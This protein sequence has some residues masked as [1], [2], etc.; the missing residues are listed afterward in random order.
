MAINKEEF[1]DLGCAVPLDVVDVKGLATGEGSGD[2][3]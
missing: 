1:T 2:M 3:T